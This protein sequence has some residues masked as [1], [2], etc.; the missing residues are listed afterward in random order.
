MKKVMK[1]SAFLLLTTVLGFTSEAQDKQA[2]RIQ[3]SYLAAFGKNASDGEVN[4]WKT[5]GNLTA[6]QLVARHQQYIAANPS[7]KKD[8]INASYMSA[9]G[10]KASDGEQA[11][12]GPSNQTYAALFSN[13]LNYLRGN[14]PEFDKVISLSYL[15]A[16]GRS[17][18][19]GEY[20]YWRKYAG[21]PY[22]LLVI[23]HQKWL[24]AN[25]QSQPLTAG[26][27]KKSG[28]ATSFTLSKSTLDELA[29]VSGGESLIVAKSAGTLVGNAG[30]TL[31]GN[32]GSTLVG[33][34]GASMVAA[35]GMN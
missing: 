28:S 15:R 32:D 5:Q 16:L 8:V 3:G 27:I 10:R 1:F 24:A 13:H 17:P 29:K 19:D 4:Y 18:N 22:Y 25:M 33:N 11:Y 6:D 2:E 7:V 12:W 20:V 30:G 9:F 21:T 35:G 31:I 23:Y 14:Q 34:D 26:D